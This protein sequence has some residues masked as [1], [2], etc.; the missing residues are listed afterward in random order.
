M[1]I[2][3]IT[4][5]MLVRNLER[6][7]VDLAVEGNLIYWDVTKKRIGVRTDSPDYTLDV[8]GNVFAG[9]TITVGYNNQALYRL[10]KAPPTERGQIITS[11]SSGSPGIPAET[12]WGPGPETVNYRR[13]RYCKVITN[14]LGYGNVQFDMRLGVSSIVYNLRVSRP[15]KVEVFGT[16]ARD[17]PNPYT[18]I[19]TQDH[20]VD[21]GTVIL[22]DGSSFQS[23]QY[24]IFANLEEP[25]KPTVYVTVTSID[26]HLASTPVVLD[27]YYYAAITESHGEMITEGSTLPASASTGDLFF[28]IDT[29]VMYYYYDGSWNAI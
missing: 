11:V 10:P 21:D 1:P 2:G 27:L 23:R 13:R 26:S 22:N 12:I 19:A 17:E 14:L 29:K 5:P 18:F 3:R 24:S 8:R 16:A 25:V 20:L 28:K 15:V 7:G 6:Q 4:G 9:N